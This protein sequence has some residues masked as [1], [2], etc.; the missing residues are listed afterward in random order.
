MDLSNV[1]NPT[2]YT[3]RLHTYRLEVEYDGTDFAGWQYQ[4]AERTVQDCLQ[5]AV[6]ELF[7]ED[8][9]VIGAGR[10]DAGVHASGQVAHFRVDSFR[11]PAVV[12]RAFNALLPGDIRVKQA[13]LASAEFHARFSAQWRGYRY[14]IARAPLA[15]GRTYCWTCPNTLDLSRL[16]QAAPLILGSH[17]FKAFAHYSEKEVHY[18]STVHR[19]EWIES[20]PH[21]EF[22][23]VA[24]RFLHGMVR[25]LVGTFVNI[26]RG[27]TEIET[28]KQIMATDDVRQAGP[29]APASGL[30]LMTVGYDAWRDD[31]PHKSEDLDTCG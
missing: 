17:R 11:E 4:P 27:K 25:L 7:G 29:K 2:E 20:G 26:G 9:P 28:F 5:K 31:N 22:H 8:V 6:R 24:N 30:T 21:L 19:V 23:I 16:R 1:E 15:I 14:R 10:T 13:C 18:L 12:M 3:K